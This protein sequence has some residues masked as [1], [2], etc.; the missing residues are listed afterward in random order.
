MTL[1]PDKQESSPLPPPFSL[2]LAI[3]N[4]PDDSLVGTGSSRRSSSGYYNLETSP[5]RLNLTD[6]VF[7]FFLQRNLHEGTRLI[8]FSFIVEC[9]RRYTDHTK[10]A[11]YVAVSFIPFFN[12]LLV[13]IYVI[14]YM[15]VCLIC[16]C[17]VL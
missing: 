5:G 1:K 2:S 3:A 15:V 16:F 4:H 7:A 17:L 9:S 10:F 8:V 12:I 6:Y 14:V 13:L 11:A